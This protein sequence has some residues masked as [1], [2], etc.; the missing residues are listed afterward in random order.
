MEA[1]NYFSKKSIA[2]LSGLLAYA[3]ILRAISWY[4]TPPPSINFTSNLL[5]VIIGIAIIIPIYIIASKITG[6]THA[7]LFSA[8]LAA[9]IPL[10]SWKVTA[11]LTHSLALL[12]FILSILSLMFMKD[13]GDWKLIILIPLIFA[14]I[15]IYA[16]LLIPILGL[17]F[18]FV[19][20]EEKEFSRNEIFYSVIAT[21]GILGIFLF[22]TSTTALFLVV[23]QYIER[24]YYSIA[25]ETFTLTSTFAFAGL[26]PTYLGVFGT[27]TGLK[28]RKK[29]VLLLMSAASILILAL[30]FR[31]VPAL[32]AFPYFSLILATLAGFFFKNL[33]K[34][35]EYTKLKSYKNI[36]YLVA[37]AIV[38]SSG[39]VH[40]LLFQ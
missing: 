9:T 29:S 20:L 13:I 33:D 36:I 25:A 30:S 24:N 8:A 35:L 4:I 38:L 1:E 16:L 21:L 40:F 22:F 39:A 18:V 26:I 5:S 27:Y 2:F 31:V 23:Q 34:N 7:G 6:M 19:K 17:Y 28:E 14:F 3:I 10:F 12:F 15:H 37:F 11:Q 32:L